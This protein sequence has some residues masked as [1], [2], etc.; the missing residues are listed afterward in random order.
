RSFGAFPASSTKT[1]RPPAGRTTVLPTRQM[2]REQT[3]WSRHVT[4][5]LRCL[6]QSAPLQ[7][8]PSNFTTSLTKSHVQ[9]SVPSGSTANTLAPLAGDRRGEDG[10]RHRHSAEQAEGRLQGHLGHVPAAQGIAL[11][12]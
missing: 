7:R 12:L 4:R 3:K 6:T 9:A 11:K 2:S 8:A 1:V 10:A 5:S